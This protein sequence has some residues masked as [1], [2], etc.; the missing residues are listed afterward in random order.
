MKPPAAD[1]RRFTFF[2][3]RLETSV[4]VEDTADGVL[5][6]ASRATFSAERKAVF[7]RELAAEGF[8]DSSYRWVA[9][10]GSK[11]VRWLVDAAWFLP[12]PACVAETRRFMPRLLLGAAFPWLLPMG[13]LLLRPRGEAGLPPPRAVPI[14]PPAH[15]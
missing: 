13:A 6:R 10:P 7:I 1:P 2:V 14:L 15:A 11:E 4:E 5:I 12:G 8:I 9:A 3:A